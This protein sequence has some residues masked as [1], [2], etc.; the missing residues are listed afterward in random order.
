MGIL[1]GKVAMIFGVAN[2]RSIA[3]GIAQAL[4]QAGCTLG[5]SYAGEALEK[6]IKPLAESIG[7]DFV[8]QCDVSNDADITA[9]FAKAAQRFGKVDIL[10][11]SIGFAPREALDG[12][13]VDTTREQWNTALDISAYSF[14]ALAREDS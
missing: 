10:V 7:V 14:V 5:F 11:H 6:R 13:F 3:W 2:N 12:L 1:D 9:V 4:H 8:E